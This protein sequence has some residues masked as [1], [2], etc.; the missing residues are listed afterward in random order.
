MKCAI[1]LFSPVIVF[2]HQEPTPIHGLVTNT[3]LGLQQFEPCNWLFSNFIAPFFKKS[4]NKDKFFYLFLAA[5]SLA[6]VR[7][8]IG[9]PSLTFSSQRLVEGR[10]SPQQEGSDPILLSRPPS[11]YGRQKRSRSIGQL[12][13]L[14][15][16]APSFCSSLSHPSISPGLSP[17]PT[18]ISSASSSSTSSYAEGCTSFSTLLLHSSYYQSVESSLQPPGDAVPRRRHRCR[19]G[20]LGYFLRHCCGSATNSVPLLLI[21][22]IV[23]LNF[24]T[25]FVTI[26][27]KLFGRLTI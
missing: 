15:V 24:I 14:P 5:Q 4:R 13:F 1:S 9:D 23:L 3:P 12:E 8:R 19:S 10:D 18:K 6:P 21:Y 20:S 7:T 25:R 16:P 17:S 27:A 11:G 2:T 26:V 22:D